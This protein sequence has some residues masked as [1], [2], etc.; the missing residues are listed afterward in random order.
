MH[1][2]SV[3]M[4]STWIR[5]KNQLGSD[6]VFL[7]I[8]DQQFDMMVMN[9]RHLRFC[10]SFPFSAPEDLLYYVIFVMEQLGLNPEETTA[11][12][13]GQVERNSLVYDALFKYIRDINFV[14]R[15]DAFSY[16]YAFN[17]I[18]GHYFSTLLNFPVCGS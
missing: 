11:S 9:S 15:N 17:E 7:N 2:A 1:H 6:R 14:D 5:Y 10:N 3:L 4:E 12:L 13:M 18:P 16:S 8:R